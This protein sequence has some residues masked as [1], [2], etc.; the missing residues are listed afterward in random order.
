M[1]KEFPNIFSKR[2][3]RY[4]DNL[5]DVSD[6]VS[7]ALF[8]LLTIAY[9]TRDHSEALELYESAKLLAKYYKATLK[10]RVKAEGLEHK[11]DNYH[12]RLEALDGVKDCANL[13]VTIPA[14]GVISLNDRKFSFLATACYTD[15]E[16]TIKHEESE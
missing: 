3:D 11:A 5:D 12:E 1:S 9:E 10:W 15:T 2:I 14:G 6:D 7:V 4:L 13:N 8:N 16:S